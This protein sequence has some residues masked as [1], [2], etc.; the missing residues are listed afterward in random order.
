[1]DD[2]TVS[3]KN[4]EAG[5]PIPVPLPPGGHGTH[6]RPRAKATEPEVRPK[7]RLGRNSR[8]KLGG[9]GGGFSPASA[10]VFLLQ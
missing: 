1:M 4:R 2:S 6:P 7:R 3:H 9:N 5:F 8:K 10:P